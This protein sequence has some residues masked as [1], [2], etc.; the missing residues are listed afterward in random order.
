MSGQFCWCRS[1]QLVGSPWPRREHGHGCDRD[2]LA[3]GERRTLPVPTLPPQ[4]VH[5]SPP[6]TATA[7]NPC[8]FVMK[9]I[10]FP[11]SSTPK[12]TLDATEVLQTGNIHLR[13]ILQIYINKTNTNTTC[14]EQRRGVSPSLKAHTFNT[15]TAL[16]PACPA[17]SF[18]TWTRFGRAVTAFTCP[19]PV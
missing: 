3:A 5:S 10:A 9:Q 6:P 17:E 16:S 13:G 19:P 8:F 7:R 4:Q 11:A 12:A 1:L 18:A 2:R 14:T 15:G